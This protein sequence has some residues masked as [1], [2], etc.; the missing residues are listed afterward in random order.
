MTVSLFVLGTEDCLSVAVWA[1]DFQ[2]A[3]AIADNDGF[4][5][6]DSGFCVPEEEVSLQ[7]RL[8]NGAIN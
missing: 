2:E 6:T 5:T 3:Q 4:Y 7:L 1:Q 8:H